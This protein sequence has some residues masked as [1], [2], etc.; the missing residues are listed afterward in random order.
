M[1]HSFAESSIATVLSVVLAVAASKTRLWIKERFAFVGDDANRVLC[2]Q[3]RGVEFRFRHA[4]QAK[5]QSKRHGNRLR[6]APQRL[7][8]PP[9]PLGKS[10]LKKSSAVFTASLSTSLTSHALA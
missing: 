2:L 6:C 8:A 1:A 9:K 7:L 5:K 10:S 4:P 3:E